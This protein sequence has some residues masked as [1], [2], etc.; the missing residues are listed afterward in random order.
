MLTAAVTSPDG[1][2]IGYTSYGHGPGVVLVPGALHS[3]HHYEKLAL[4]LADEFTV[5][6]IDRRGRPGSG[7]QRPDHDIAAECADVAAVLEKTGSSLLF[8]H[9]SGGV[10]ALQTTLRYDVRKVAVYEPPV[11]FA[12]SRAPVADVAAMQKAVAEGRK[13]DAFAILAKGEG[14]PIQVL[15][16]PALRML[17]RMASKAAEPPVADYIDAVGTYPAEQRMIM[18]LAGDSDRYRS[19]RAETLVLLGSRTGGEL[20]RSARFLAET[21]PG[22]RLEI[23]RGLGHDAPDEKAPERV[24]AALKVLFAAPG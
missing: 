8:G 1:T 11:M 23:M 6:A 15:P 20:A 16:M 10:V 14:G 18:A 21:I 4:A 12:D 24:A 5:H 22:A 2:S 9:S 13:P 3:G 19:V 17:F 7:P